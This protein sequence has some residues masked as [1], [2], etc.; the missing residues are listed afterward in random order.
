[1]PEI[2]EPSPVHPAPQIVTDG[3]V[4]DLRTMKELQ[5]H[6]LSSPVPVLLEFG[7]EWCAPCL[8][9]AP[10]L[11]SLAAARVHALRVVKVDIDKD[12]IKWMQEPGLEDFRIQGI[13]H[14][15]VVINGK[16]A[17]RRGGVFANVEEMT[18]WLDAATAP[19]PRQEGPRP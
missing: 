10:M 3:R 16:V 18:A 7:A 1:M 17:A 4:F 6:V 14:F 15:L 19:K 13:P 8:R 12:E 2:P 11:D 9:T 5:D